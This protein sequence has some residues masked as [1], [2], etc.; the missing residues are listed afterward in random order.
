[1]GI[2]GLYGRYISKEIAQAILNYIPKYVSSLSI[3][4]NAMIHDAR[5]QVFGEVNHR[6][7]KGDKNTIEQIKISLS[8]IPEE[9]LWNKIFKQVEKNILDAVKAFNPRDTLILAVDGPTPYGKAMQQRSR[10][11]KSAMNP[12][13]SPFD[14]NA[15]SVGTNFMLGLDAYLREF[16]IQSKSILPPTV[17]YSDHNTVGEGEHKIMDYYRSGAVDKYHARKGA[18]HILYGL[19]ADLIMLSI[20]SSQ[21]KIYLSRQNIRYC[22]D[23]DKVKQGLNQMGITV[24]D[25]VIACMLIGN[26]FLPQSPS[27]ENLDKS[28]NFLVNTCAQYN[29][30][31]YSSNGIN[32]NNMLKFLEIVAKQENQNLYDI[33]LN[34]I[35]ENKLE[36]NKFLSYAT[37]Q[38]RS[39]YNFYPNLFKQAWYENEVLPKSNILNKYFEFITE[40]D[41]VN[42]IGHM[43]EAYANTIEWVYLYYKQGTMSVNHDW[44]Y[45]FYHTPLLSDFYLFM[46]NN[47]VKWDFRAKPDMI[48]FNSLQQLV[49]TIPM[50]SKKILPKE[51]LPLYDADSPLR[52]LFPKSFL[53]EMDGK[54]QEHEAIAIVPFVDKNRIVAAVSTLSIPFES[55][56]KWISTGDLI[57]VDEKRVYQNKYKRNN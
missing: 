48:V 29:L 39:H 12:S 57:S 18:V 37:K 16:I 56:K 9:Q 50:N 28:V 8:Q 6:G 1:M 26:D 11:E 25:F 4:L 51:L 2:P 55:M 17:I 30:K 45:P 21:N 36:S 43:C 38:E 3:D 47:R 10:R 24:D 49:S 23:I 19:D 27:M 52:D 31:L 41:Y 14:R 40:D 22:V 42:K 54:V 44:Y 32:W 33:Q 5:A 7:V 46:S 15:I 13:N 35:Q 20:L 53:I 34:L